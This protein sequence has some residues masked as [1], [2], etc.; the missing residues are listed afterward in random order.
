MLLKVLSAFTELEREIVILG[1]WNKR[2][3]EGRWSKGQ[4]KGL[5]WQHH[6]KVELKTWDK[7]AGASK[8]RVSK[9]LDFLGVTQKFRSPDAKNLYTGPLTWWTGP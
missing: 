4:R 3:V 7:K 9:R 1:A 5:L 2:A 6:F 8:R